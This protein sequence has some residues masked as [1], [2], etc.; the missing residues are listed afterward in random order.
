MIRSPLHASADLIPC[1]RQ[2]TRHAQE[3]TDYSKQL[4]ASLNLPGA[5]EALETNVGLPPEVNGK[6][7]GCSVCLLD[8]AQLWTKIREV[9]FKGGASAL[10]DIYSRCFALACDLASDRA[11][12]I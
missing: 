3:S 6:G 1:F 10:N 2:T 9:Q 11:L 4:L 8:G 5:L 7:F 12:R